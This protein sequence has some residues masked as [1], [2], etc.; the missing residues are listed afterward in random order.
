MLLMPNGRI[1]H[2][3]LL[4]SPW[5]GRAAKPSIL[6]ASRRGRPKQWARAL[7]PFMKSHLKEWME[8]VRL[9]ALAAG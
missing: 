9:A 2:G 6:A 3:N 5:Q 1:P 7:Q 4:G 8:R